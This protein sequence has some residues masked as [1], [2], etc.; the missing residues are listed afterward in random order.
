M[1]RVKQSYETLSLL[2]VI[3]LITEKCLQKNASTKAIYCNNIE[4]LPSLMDCVTFV[5][6]DFT[7]FA[8]TTYS[9]Q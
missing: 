8:V 1:H 7:Q 3:N 4:A 5:L 2:A 6:Y 9:W